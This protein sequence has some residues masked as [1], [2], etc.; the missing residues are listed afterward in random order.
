MSATAAYLIGFLVLIV[1]VVMGAHQ[2]GL[3]DR[4]IAIIAVI[5]A[6]VGIMAAFTKTRSKEPP[7]ERS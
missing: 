4:W 6:G 5:L 1:G 3:S 7:A 2:L